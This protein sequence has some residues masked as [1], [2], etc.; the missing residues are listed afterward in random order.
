M[1]LIKI[2]ILVTYIFFLIILREKK[3]YIYLFIKY[4]NLIYY[5]FLKVN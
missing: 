1:K 4:I 2:N 5:Y 3:K